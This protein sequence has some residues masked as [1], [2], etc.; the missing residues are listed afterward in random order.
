MMR[1]RTGLTPVVRGKLH[2]VVGILVELTVG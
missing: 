1:G 2:V